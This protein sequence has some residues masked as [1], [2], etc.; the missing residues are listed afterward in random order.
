MR[1]QTSRKAHSAI[2]HISI[3]IVHSN[4]QVVAKMFNTET[5]KI[6]KCTPP[7]NNKD[8]WTLGR[9]MNAYISKE[10][11]S[12]VTVQQTFPVRNVILPTSSFWVG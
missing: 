6:R 2:S 9:A 12:A 1:R 8:G 7:S 5:C 10:V 11:E 3:F 4:E